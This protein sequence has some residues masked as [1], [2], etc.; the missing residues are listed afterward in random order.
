MKK[1]HIFNILIIFIFVIVSLFLD[2]FKE[3]YSTLSLTNKGYFLFL[4]MGLLSGII[5]G[6]ETYYISGIKYGIIMFLSL[7]IG[8]IVPHDIS[9]NIQG[10]LHLINAY[11]GFSIMMIV[12]FINI[13]KFSL[14]NIKKAKYIFYLTLIVLFISIYF[15]LEYMCVNTISELLIMIIVQTDHLLLTRSHA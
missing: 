11:F 5:L 14:R 7:L 12:T 2:P 4:S 6:I 8:V 10:N 3:N 15:Y 1:Y 9:Y 13:Y